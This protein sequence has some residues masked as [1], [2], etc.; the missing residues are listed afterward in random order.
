MAKLVLSVF[1]VFVIGALA[2]I[3]SA[4]YLL[5]KLKESPSYDVAYG[6]VHQ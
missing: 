6:K 5:V 4:K 3:A 1:L 2:Q